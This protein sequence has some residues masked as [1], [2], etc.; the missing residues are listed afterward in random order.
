MMDDVLNPGN[1]IV[2]SLERP[3]WA[4]GIW[5]NLPKE[6]FMGEGQVWHIQMDI[7]MTDPTTNQGIECDTSA[8]GSG[9]C[10]YFLVHSKNIAGDSYWVGFRDHGMVWNKDGWNHFSVIVDGKAPWVD[11][12]Q[13]RAMI[14]GGP[15]GSN[16]LIDNVSV[17]LYTDPYV[18]PST[19]DVTVEPNNQIH[20]SQKA[21]ECWTPGS[22][23][24]ITSNTEKSNDYQIATIAST[25]PF[26]GTIQ[27]TSSI[28]PVSTVASD[29]NHAVEVAL[30]NRRIIFEADDDPNDNLIGGHLIVML[31][32]QVVQHLE[33]VEIRNFGQ[34]GNLGRYPVHFHLC[35]DGTGSVVKK[36]VV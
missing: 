34:Q 22:E 5:Q 21:A 10:P 30:L 3:N 36:N 24:L 32:P 25:N 9:D 18:P 7:R 12:K 20:L 4:G 2:A 33:G 17:E 31:T 16:L 29:P 13:W 1:R 28:E 15:A 23:I 27:L 14:L 19:N 8:T 26:T 11:L 6:C 35:D